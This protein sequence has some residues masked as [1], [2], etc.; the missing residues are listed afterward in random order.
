[1]LEGLQ[2]WLVNAIGRLVFA[3]VPL[4]CAIKHSLWL[5][6]TVS[7]SAPVVQAMMVGSFPIASDIVCTLPTHMMWFRAST[8]T[9]SMELSLAHARLDIVL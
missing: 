5:I 9:R 2:R 1:M 3:L 4:H 7:V 6:S 8:A